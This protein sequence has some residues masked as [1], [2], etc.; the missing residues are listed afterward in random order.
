MNL[1][2]FVPRQVRGF[3]SGSAQQCL[4]GDALGGA[5]DICPSTVVL[6]GPLATAVHSSI[7]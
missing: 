5:P 3:G 1:V 6:R 2:P 4:E 7:G